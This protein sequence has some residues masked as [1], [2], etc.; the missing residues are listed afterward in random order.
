[1]RIH[2]LRTGLMRKLAKAGYTPTEVVF[3]KG[4]VRA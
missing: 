2:T 3:R 4:V 1:V